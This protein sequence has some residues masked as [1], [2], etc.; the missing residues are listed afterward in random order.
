[1]ASLK[2]LKKKRGS[3]LK[4]LQEKLEQSQNNGAPR[5]ERL[6]W[7]KFNKEKGKGTCIVRFLTPKE[8]DAYV[9]EKSYSFNGPGGN[10][11]DFA[12]QT[13][14]EEDP[15]QI[16]AINCFRKAKATGDERYKVEGKK[17]MPQSKYYANVMVIKDE[18]NPENEGKVFIYRFG[19]QIY[20]MIEEKIKPE[21]DDVEAMDPFDYWEGADFVIRMVGKEIPDKRTGQKVLVPNYEK[22]SFADPSEFLEGDEDAIDAIYQQTYDLA[23]FI[24]PSKAKSFDEVAER[25]KKVMNKPYNWLSDEGVEE[26]QEDKK[27]EDDLQ[28]GQESA[29]EEKSAPE[30]SVSKSAP[31]KS[32]EKSEDTGEVEGESALERFRRLSKK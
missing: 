25:F 14:G 9:E 23:P 17:F 11:W 8:N 5:D 32:E 1:M 13:I 15:V 21:F 12:R 24:D 4:K 16:A 28:K 3:N 7:P 10:F 2:D 26:H 20:M 30:K 29:P 27:A 6:W 22:S 31:E 19:R 18:E